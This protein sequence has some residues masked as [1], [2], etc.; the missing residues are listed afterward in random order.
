MPSSAHL[1]QV[2]GPVNLKITS[3]PNQLYT[4]PFKILLEGRFNFVLIFSA[5]TIL[6][7]CGKLNP[8]FIFSSQ[9]IGM[10]HF[11]CDYT[12]AVFLQQCELIRVAGTEPICELNPS[13]GNGVS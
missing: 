6:P 8:I 11:G 9:L 10:K 5:D 2:K 12:S 3:F 13:G 4:S 7:I 1:G